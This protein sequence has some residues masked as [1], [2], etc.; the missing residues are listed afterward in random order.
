VKSLLLITGNLTLF[1][2]GIREDA[3]PAELVVRTAIVVAVL[4]AVFIALVEWRRHYAERGLSKG[5]DARAS[6]ERARRASTRV[7]S[8]RQSSKTPGAPL[9]GGAAAPD[10]GPTA[11]DTPAAQDP[12]APRDRDAERKKAVAAMDAIQ[13]LMD[14][15]GRDDEWA[16]SVEAW[17]RANYGRRPGSHLERVECKKT[18]CAVS[19]THDTAQVYADWVA[20]FTGHDRGLRA[21]T[22]PE[23][24]PSGKTHGRT[25]IL[26]DEHAAPSK[27]R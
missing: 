7:L 12:D 11:Q 16:P 9:S 2:S 13:S 18:L 3:S 17:T 10:A 24:L 5:L 8:P 1:L 21:M 22:M 6:V 25:F 19:G 4:F 27:V 14:A 15:E 20:R 26:K 23:V